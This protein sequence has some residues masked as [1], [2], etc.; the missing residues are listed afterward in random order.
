MQIKLSN[1]SKS[2]EINICFGENTLFFKK[3]SKEYSLDEGAKCFI[4]QNYE[5]LVDLWNR[6]SRNKTKY[7]NNIFYYSSPLLSGIGYPPHYIISLGI[8]L[9]IKKRLKGKNVTLHTQRPELISYYLNKKILSK[10]FDLYSLFKVLC[11]II[12]YLV[13]KCFLITP[14]KN[15]KTIIVHSNHADSFFKPERGYVTSKVP[16]LSILEKEKGYTVLYDINPNFFTFFNIIKFSSRKIVYAPVYLS[17][18]EIISICFQSAVFT[19][20][21]YLLWKSFYFSV[22]SVYYQIFFNILKRKSIVAM[23][24]Q[25]DNDYK[26]IMPWENRGFQLGVECDL[27]SDNLINYECGLLSK[28][29]SE[30]NSYRH[31]RHTPSAT[32]LAMSKGSADFLSILG[33]SSGI[34]I[35]K[36][37]RVFYLKAKDNGCTN[38]DTVLVICPSDKALTEMMLKDAFNTQHHFNIK[39]KLHPYDK[40]KVENKYFESRP[41]FSC[42]SD[43][44]IAVFSGVTSASMEVY[45]AGLKVYRYNN[46]NWLCFDTLDGIDVSSINS[47]NEIEADCENVENKKMELINYYLGINEIDFVSYLNKQIEN[48][49]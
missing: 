21:N 13:A 26:Y 17:F 28:T 44:S 4:E 45:L 43:Y 42:L 35:V 31:L 18:L 47:F 1:H 14:R 11:F 8:I 19:I 9:Y 27:N 37:P 5:Y 36:S 33:P 49:K 34:D 38:K 48:D 3:I 46:P 10:I 25:F 30:Y 32:L 41:L 29:C 39:I 22:D 20:K 2:E 6:F 24:R 16:D 7:L 23:L 15:K 12:T 40:R